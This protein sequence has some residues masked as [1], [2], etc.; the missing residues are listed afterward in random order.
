MMLRIST[1]SA[2][3]LRCGP[4][5][6][7]WF[8]IAV[9]VFAIDRMLRARPASHVGQK[10]LETIAPL[11]ANGNSPGAVV[12][13]FHI[14]AVVAAGFHAPP[15]P[16]L[17]A[18]SSARRVAMRLNSLSCALVSK[19]AATERSIESQTCAGN[20]TDGSAVASAS[21]FSSADVF[22]HPQSSDLH[23]R[24]V[25]SLAHSSG[26]YHLFFNVA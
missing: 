17:R 22:K 3:F 11:L 13:V 2:L 6:I 19:T 18:T 23:C 9:V 26:L 14:V 1:V 10:R 16:V 25:D 20:D 15:R 12:R 7:G 4:A 8:V 21:P 24:E 5:A